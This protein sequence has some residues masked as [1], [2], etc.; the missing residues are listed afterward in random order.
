MLTL[1]AG[2]IK[3][4]KL[5]CPIAMNVTRSDRQE[6]RKVK[7]VKKIKIKI[8][9]NKLLPQLCRKTHGTLTRPG[10]QKMPEDIAEERK[11]EKSKVQIAR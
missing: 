2:L 5:M 7:Y 6:E 4:D 11:T 1:A 10:R 9:Q 8:K 3:I